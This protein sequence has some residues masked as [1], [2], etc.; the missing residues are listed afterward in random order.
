[1]L[2]ISKLLER[3]TTYKLSQLCNPWSVNIV[4]KFVVENVRYR[5]GD[6]I[7]DIGCG[8]GNY[9]T[10]FPGAS[11]TGID[12]NPNYIEAARKNFG[13]RF[14][15]MDAG[16]M[17]FAENSFD[18]AITVAAC[19]HLDDNRIAQMVGSCMKVLKPGGILHVIDAV[20]PDRPSAFLKYGFFMLDRG[21]N[22][23]TFKRMCELLSQ[24]GDVSHAELG[25]GPVH[26]LC[27]LRLERH[28]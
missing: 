27:Y 11:Y 3:P 23:R 28:S 6:H 26:D 24:F 8:L 21:G 20:L 13:D 9:S 10:M 5:P 17:T 18:H 25:R 22:Q 2:A 14:F 19:H 12:I 4:R 7:L 15:V 16:A 1:M